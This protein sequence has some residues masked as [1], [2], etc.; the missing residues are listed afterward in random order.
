MPGKTGKGN[1]A[2]DQANILTERDI[3]ERIYIAI[4]EQRLVPGTR[5]PEAKLCEAFG[6]GRM[7]IR[8]ALL[9][10]GNQGIVDL[11]SNR[12]ACIACPAPS[13]ARDVFA[14]RQVIEPSI[15]RW[16]IERASDEDINRLRQHIELEEKARANHDR[17]E[18]IRLSGDFH[19]QLARASGNQVVTQLIRELVTKTSLIIGMFGQAGTSSCPEQEHEDIL[20]AISDRRISTVER[21]IGQHLKHIESDVN[22]STPRK[23]EDDLVRI[24][25]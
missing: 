2:E 25:A 17:R 22:L 12:G 24:L 18:M 9:L 20:Q 6:V 19:N 15:S 21:L 14:T 1:I 4:M 3:V 10:L 7:R 5:L 16:V 23:G 11:H 8:R 13:E